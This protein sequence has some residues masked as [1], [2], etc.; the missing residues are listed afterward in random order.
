MN[1]DD[2]IAELEFKADAER[3]H[4]HDLMEAEIYG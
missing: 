2:Y 3:S 1:E 4:E